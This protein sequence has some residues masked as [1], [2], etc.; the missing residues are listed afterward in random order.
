MKFSMTGQAKGDLLIQVDGDNGVLG[1]SV[2]NHAGVG[3]RRG[4]VNVTIHYLY[5]GVMTVEMILMQRRLV[6]QNHVHVSCN[7]LHCYLMYIQSNLSMQSLL[8][9]SHLY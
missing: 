6:I 3:S 7:C 4:H 1:P 8:L 9:S 5:M 2:V